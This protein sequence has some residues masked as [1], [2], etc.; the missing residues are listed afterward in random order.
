MNAKF[1]H[2]SGCKDGLRRSAAFTLVELMI[3][4]GI[5]SIAIAIV[6]TFIV[7][8]AKGINGIVKQTAINDQASYAGEFMFNRIRFA[9]STAVATDG[10]TLSM[11][12]D[13][14][15]E[16]DSTNSNVN[17]RDGIAY[18]DRDHFEYFHFLNGDGN[19]GTYADNQLVY[20]NALTK[21]RRVL[22]S[23]WVSKLTNQ[24]VFFVQT[25][26]SPAVFVRYGLTDDK[27]MDGYQHV[28]IRT[29]FVPRNRNDNDNAITISPDL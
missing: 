28:D 11:T 7:M 24:P 12:F 8:A 9:T 3:A 10:N 4:M 2:A 15:C 19:D 6:S 23:A 14:N 26:T 29:R 22:I 25:N 18:N 21:E 20:S 17:S 1:P 16:L 13:D 27:V 5:A